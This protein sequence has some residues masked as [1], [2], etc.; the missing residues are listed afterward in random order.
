MNMS[1]TVRNDDNER[2]H[3][4]NPG[5]VQKAGAALLVIAVIAGACYAIAHTVS[6]LLL[7]FVLA[8]LL[9]PFVSFM[10]RRKI[11][12]ICGI[13]LLYTVLT[14]LAFSSVIFLLPILSDRW[15]ALVHDLPGY[16]QKIKQIAFELKW[17][18]G[19]TYAAEEWSWLVDSIQS[20]IDRILSR[21]GAG[22]YAAAFSVVFNLFNLL[23]AP[24]LVFFMLYYKEE[25]MN[26]IVRWV[27]SSHRNFL[28]G[29]G[30]DVNR[31][32]GGFIRGQV[33]V[34]VIVAAI[35]M[36]ALMALH[37]Q[38]PI[39]C[40]IFAGISSFI[41]FIGVVLATI[42]PLFFAYVEY[43]G[44]VIIFQ[45]IV[46]FSVIYFLEGYV[47]KPLV[48]KNAMNLNPLITIIMVLALGELFGFWGIMLAVPVTGAIKIY[49]SHLRGI[50]ETGAE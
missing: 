21:L 2:F 40:G 41:P 15:N 8:Y 24:V 20:G 38:H 28:L 48:F 36:A 17:R 23:L 13:L 32:I 30:R 43:Q 7:S 3:L 5:T 33:I 42:P 9:D 49:C 34:S 46:V 37:V 45:V 27:P 22:I 1:R 14:L 10:E 35:S 19:P 25:A 6:C 29:V 31:S 16:L 12:R 11:R 44:G 39:F 50:E 18:F 26:G 4:F 47:I